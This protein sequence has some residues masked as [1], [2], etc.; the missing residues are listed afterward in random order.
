[1]PGFAA[2]ALACGVVSC[3]R[4]GNQSQRAWS[5]VLGVLITILTLSGESGNLCFPQPK[6]QVRP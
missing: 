4:A 6:P 3:L 1:M 5:L 2:I